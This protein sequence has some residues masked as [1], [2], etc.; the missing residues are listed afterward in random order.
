MD[1]VDDEAHRA[2]A[3]IDAV[4][5]FG[6]RLS[7]PELHRYL[8]GPNRRR[9]GTP[10]AMRQILATLLESI[11]D[12]H[13]ETTPGES[14]ADF[15][16]RVGWVSVSDGEAVTLTGLGRAMLAHAE[17]PPSVTASDNPMVV[18]IDPEDPVAY[19]RVFELMST[20]GPGMLIDPYLD[21]ER[22]ADLAEISEVTRVL[23]SDRTER[24]RLEHLR[25]ILPEVPSIAIRVAGKSALHDR[26]FM[27]DQGPVFV[28]G[29][30][31]NSIS[32]RP[33]V[34]TPV[35]DALA[36]GAMRNEYEE[37][38]KQAEPLEPQGPTGEKPE[39]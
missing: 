7:V 35:A 31:L 39:P 33:G 18:Q 27:P 14:A 6:S 3:Y 32:K 20:H 38:W 29:S 11:R 5:R 8:D 9:G 36:S 23:T 25:R 2:L 28:L 17:R 22:L 21:F 10:I 13:L 15:L 30:S 1:L 24:K 16:K 19:V 37:L 4:T 34:I 26:F 12:V